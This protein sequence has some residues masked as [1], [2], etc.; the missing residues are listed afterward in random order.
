MEGAISVKILNFGS[1]NLDYVYSVDHIV[2]P[3]ETISSTGLELFCGGKGLNQ[4]VALARAGAEVYHAGMVGPDGDILL[5]TCR[6]N[7]VD[8]LH[9]KE[10]DER[11]GNAIIQVSEKGQNS[12]V[13]FGGANRKNEKAHVD[14]VLSQFEAGDAVLLQ[15]EINL[16]EY[17]IEQAAEKG[18]IIVLN[19]SPFDS[20]L[21][22]CDLGKVSIFLMN[23]VEGEQITGES[24]PQKILDEIK[25]L[26]PRVKTVLTLGKAGAAY[27]DEAVSCTHGTYDVKVVDTTA[28]GDTFTGYF[29]AA[30]MEGRPPEQALEIASI[31]SS[32]AVSRKGAVA[33]IPYRREVE[34]W[35]KR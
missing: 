23:E 16:V 19:P 22:A 24:Q 18:M 5:R 30:T 8:T 35:M 2:Q 28:A 31:A 15:N 29:L 9:I 6:E 32:I 26:Y 27:Q 11:S 20:A 25:V 17:I 14:A 13:L 21:N 4:S 34:E 33:S 1:L 3:G 10:V 7:G 12:I